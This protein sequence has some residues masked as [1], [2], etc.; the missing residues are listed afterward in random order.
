[1][2]LLPPWLLVASLLLGL[3]VTNSNME[4]LQ[5]H[6]LCSTTVAHGVLLGTCQR[7]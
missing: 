6:Y 7:G 2:R 1:M 5:E 3:F 4:S